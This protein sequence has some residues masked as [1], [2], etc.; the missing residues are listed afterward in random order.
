[1][2]AK[3]DP[4]DVC[5]IVLNYAMSVNKLENVHHAIKLLKLN[6]D[7]DTKNLYHVIRY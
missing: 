6:Y 3:V 4:K 5:M 2:E 7:V 1:M